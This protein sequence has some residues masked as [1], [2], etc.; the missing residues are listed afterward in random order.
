MLA[1]SVAALVAVTGVSAGVV[2][3]RGTGG[4]RTRPLRA[5]SAIASSRTVAAEIAPPP[6]AMTLAP[7][8]DPTPLSANITD[9][10]VPGARTRVTTP[11]L[12]KREHAKALSKSS[13]RPSAPPSPAR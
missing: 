8:E 3:S 12:R 4:G 9:S 1:A 6:K 10:M 5:Q 13:Q 11:G 7:D 2:A